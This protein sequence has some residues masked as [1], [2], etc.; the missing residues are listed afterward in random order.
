MHPPGGI[1]GKARAIT[2]RGAMPSWSTVPM[3]NWDC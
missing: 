1:N 2:L 3:N